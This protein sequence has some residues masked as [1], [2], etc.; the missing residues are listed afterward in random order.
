MS[1]AHT[2]PPYTQ[3]TVPSYCSGYVTPADV[4]GLT[5]GAIVGIVIAALA[6]IGG[7]IACAVCCGG[8]CRQPQVI[9][10]QQPQGP[11]VVAMG[12]APQLPQPGLA[13]YGPQGGQP[14][15]CAAVPQ[16]EYAPAPKV[17]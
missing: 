6:I 17:V 5:V 8:C 3:V 9:L 4:V 12:G 16:P 1:W 13:Y 15:Y 14:Q 2:H 11:V 7:I 10:Q